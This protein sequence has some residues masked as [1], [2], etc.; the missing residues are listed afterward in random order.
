MTKLAWIFVLAATSAS[1]AGENTAFKCET[2]Q[3]IDRGNRPTK[4]EFSVKNLLKGKI[5][6]SSSYDDDGRATR[7]EYGMPVKHVPKHSVLMLNEN[8][9]ITRTAKGDL[10]LTSDGDGCQWTTVVLYKDA[11]FKAGFARVKGSSGCGAGDYYSTLKCQ[12]K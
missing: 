9:G 1:A 12:V 2:T 11:G 10:E 3:V 4:I 8:Y 5:G 6:Y 7:E